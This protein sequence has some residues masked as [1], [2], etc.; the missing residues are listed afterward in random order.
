MRVYYN[1]EDAN[2]KV[3]FSIFYS[4]ASQVIVYANSVQGLDYGMHTCDA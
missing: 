3:A 1:S 4:V 2:D